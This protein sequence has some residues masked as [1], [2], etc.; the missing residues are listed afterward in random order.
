M[1]VKENI[2]EIVG[3]YK[4]KTLIT[5]NCYVVYTGDLDLNTKLDL[6]IELESNGYKV[7][8]DQN[9]NIFIVTEKEQKFELNY[10]VLNEF[11]NKVTPKEVV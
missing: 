3:K 7:I 2:I 1:I 6:R 9:F 8:E 10:D 5:E 4:L 11:L